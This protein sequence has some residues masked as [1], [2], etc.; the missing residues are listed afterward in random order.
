M[1]QEDNYIVI[2]GIRYD[3][4]VDS[5][6]DNCEEKCALCDICFKSP[7]CICVDLFSDV[8]SKEVHFERHK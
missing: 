3:V 5:V 6:S 2:N 1:K 7:G 4:V 8:F